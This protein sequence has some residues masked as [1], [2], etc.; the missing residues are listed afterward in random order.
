[1]TPSNP[2]CE[3][4]RNPVGIDTAQPRFS[5][6][7]QSGK[8]GQLQTA[9][10]V[11]VASSPDKLAADTG[12]KW[13]SGKV[14]SDQTVNVPYAGESLG[15]AERC[16]WKVRVWDAEDR[17]GAWSEA[18]TFEMGLLNEGDW[19]GKWIAADVGISSP[20]FR[21]ELTLAGPV[22]R[23]RAY[24]CGLGYYELYVNGASVG[25]HV[26]DPAPTWYDNILPVDVRSRV[27]YV[28][29]DVTELL[30]QGPNAVGVMLGHGW[31]SSDDGKPAGR[32]PFADRPILLL[33]MNVELADGRTVSLSTD[34]AWKTSPGPVTANDIAAG[35]HYDARLAQPGWN[36]AGFDDAS[37]A[38]AGAAR[39]PS[40]RLVAQ[41]VE[42]IRITQRFRPTRILKTGENSCIFDMGQYISGWT[43][44]RVRGPAGARVT[45][46]HAGRANYDTGRLDTRNNLAWSNALQLDSY[47]LRGGG[48]EIW[49]PR[50]TVHGFRYVEVAGYPGEPTADDVTGCAV[51]SD[52]EA[53]GEFACSNELLNRIHHN[54]CWTF[55]GSFQGIPQD[56]ADRAERVAW[57]GDPGFVAEDY[58]VNFSDVRFWSKW[59]DDISDSQKPDGQVPFICPPNWGEGSYKPW[60]C[61]EC[62]YSLFAWF[63]YQ[64]YGD[65]RVLAKHYE[66][67]RKQVEYFRRLAKNHILDEPLGDHMEPRDDGTSSFAPTRTPPALTGTAYYHRCAWILSQAA[68]ILGRAQDAEQYLTLA[69]EIKDAFNREFL[70]GETNQYG[71]GS[72]TANALALYLDLVPPERQEAVL[73]N[74][75]D[76]INKRGGHLSTGIIG[77]DALEQALPRHGRADVMYGIATKTTFPSW[78]YGVVNGQ[79]T[80][81]E[82]FEC[83]PCRS[84]SMK[85]LGSVEK[86]FYKDL[87]GIGLASP[88]WQKVDIAPKVMADLTWARASIGSIR[89]RVAVEWHKGDQALT[90][91]VTIPANTTA[92]VA[93]PKLDLQDVVVA[94]GGRAVW[95]AGGFV[96]GVEGIAGG[97]EAGNCVRLA[98][99]S[100]EYVFELTGRLNERRKQA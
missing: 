54:V 26:M 76:D 37:W 44:L 61:W 91:K 77:T 29:C 55:R 81:S 24:I 73:K 66:G 59:L 13:D 8:R 53:A 36:A 96:A 25:D 46:Q 7:P 65:E 49:H 39:A 98:V 100:G 85:M 68:R 84:V 52:I 28:T 95:R 75:V 79:T 16:W 62:S 87:A 35:E 40:G 57:L 42:P 43:E 21:R 33:Q 60:P 12:D 64:Y 74:L 14:K 3:Y 15:S 20:L 19:Q 92:T 69:N 27:L 97:H 51:N 22:R 4:A 78:G 38:Q 72:Q 1:M 34:D 41:S 48:L 5:W 50:F 80:I 94:E 9:Y 10:Q 56:A 89:G 31:Y 11:L 70:N 88:G 83:S 32:K 47:T 63:V 18:A 82:D 93:V 90:M 45:L 99:G 2:T 23:A 86:F 71:Q 58:M 17:G 67:M 30:R 6:I